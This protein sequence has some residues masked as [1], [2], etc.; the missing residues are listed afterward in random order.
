M[1]YGD[2][3]V[4]VPVR[5]EPATERIV[6]DIFRVMP[7]AK[8]LVIYKGKPNISLRGRNLRVVP[9]KGSGKG[10]AVIQA[11]KLVRTP[12]MCIIDGDATYDVKD[13]KKATDLVKGGADMVTG[14]RMDHIDPKAM[15]GYIRFGNRVLTTMCNV[16]YGT[17]LVDSQTG[18]RAIRKSAFDKMQF[19]E[20]HF[21]IETEMAVKFRKR[22]FKLV[23]IPIKYYPRVGETKHVKG[24]GGIKLFFI[25]FKFLFE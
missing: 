8:A 15:P 11:A 12:I 24:L 17:H 23:E 19:T 10:T 18:L 7:G 13:L 16:L 6:R 1:S 25:T 21:G 2:T 22:D 3:T 14:N 4:I 5:D 20:T 9:Q